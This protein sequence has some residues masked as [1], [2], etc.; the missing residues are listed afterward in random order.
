TNAEWR[1]NL[2]ATRTTNGRNGMTAC[3]R[4]MGAAVN[5]Y[6]TPEEK[7][8]FSN[9]LNTRNIAMTRTDAFDYVLPAA[10]TAGLP[11]LQVKLMNQQ[12]QGKIM[13]R[14]ADKFQDLQTRRLKLV[15]LGQQF[16]RLDLTKS[17]DNIDYLARAEDAFN[18]A[19]RP[20]DELR[21][22]E[23]MRTSRT[24]FSGQYRPRYF[25]LLL[26]KNPLRLVQFAGQT[27]T[28]GDE[29]VN[30]AVAHGD[31]RL[32]HSAIT[33]RGAAEDPV[34]LSAYTALTGVYFNEPTPQ[35]QNAF[36]TALGDGT[37]GERL[38][39]PRDRKTSLAGDNWFYYG[40]RYGEYL[41]ATHKGDP[42][43]FV[44]AEIEH[45]PSRA[46]AYFSAA[47]YYEESGD[48]TR[49]LADYGHVLELDSNRIDVHNRLAGIYWKQR[50]NDAAIEEW[51]R[52]LELLKAQTTTGKVL[53][54]F[55]GDYSATLNNLASRKLTAQFQP[56]INEI[57]HAY[58]KRNGNYQVQPLLVSTLPRLDPSA[59]TALLLDLSADAHE[60]L[61][62]LRTFAKVDNTLK[63]DPEPIYRRVIELAQDTA[64]KA[65]G[66]SKE[67][68]QQD[69]EALQVR[70]L[71]YLLAARKYDRL[72]D[73]INALPKS[74]W[75]AQQAALVPIQLQLAAQ[76]NTLDNALDGYRTDVDHAPATE[77]LRKAAIQLAQAGDKQSARKILEFVFARE[78]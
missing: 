33:S 69:L 16:E 2:L 24:S 18:L 67:Y 59:A 63:Y 42:E 3:M 58:V 47:L 60:K 32:A 19:G 68:A 39:K 66:V 45:T 29:V 72:R 51:K 62:F 30:F 35:V 65:E 9:A 12:L 57:L 36:V 41:G 38:S 46:G 20:N 76:S 50:R 49:A 21:A 73:E 4:E 48:L 26:A 55:W 14:S 74:I 64:Q 61:N 77:I 6:F 28:W 8:A 11:D 44:P 37:I 75:D 27:K 52:I 78:I 25:E 56:A 40:S 31:A 70:W 43:D 53:D 10:E 17:D 23:R 1:K 22:L 13:G 34:W 54:T 7:L 71:E 5:K 15:E